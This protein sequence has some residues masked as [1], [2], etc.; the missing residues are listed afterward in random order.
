MPAKRLFHAAVLLCWGALLG[1]LPACDSQQLKSKGAGTSGY[2]S[3]PAH[4]DG[5]GKVYLGREIAHVMSA[6]GGEWLERDTRQEEENVTA[7]IQK[8]DLLPTSVVADV[9]A[10]TG[11]Y[12][13]RIAQQVPQGKVYAVEVQ[14]EFISALKNRAQ[15]L[16]LTNVTV[17]QGSAQSPNLPAA[18]LDLAIMVDVYHE[19]EYPCEMLQALHRALKPTGKL[20]LLEYRAEDP[21]VPIKELHKMSVTQVNKELR[22]NGF[23]LSRRENFLPIQHFLLFAKAPKQ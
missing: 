8:L 11:Y 12:T 18:S 19:L 22:A 17:V 4:P 20:L 2:S 15:E 5:T 3:K 1:L 23:T 16:G 13:F 14:N 7:A 9:G 21:T 10:G 6:S